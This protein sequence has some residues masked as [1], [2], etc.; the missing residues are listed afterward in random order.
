[1]TGAAELLILCGVDPRA[2][3][4]SVSSSEHQRAPTGASSWQ[5][6]H[7][8]PQAAESRCSTSMQAP[9]SL[10]PCRAGRQDTQDSRNHQLN[11]NPSSTPEVA[12]R[13]EWMSLCTSVF[14]LSRGVTVRS[15]SAQTCTVLPTVPGRSNG[16][17]APNKCRQSALRLESDPLRPHNAGDTG[18]SEAR[19]LTP[20]PLSGLSSPTH[21]PLPGTKGGQPPPS[22]APAAPPHH[23]PS[24]TEA[25]WEI[26]PPGPEECSFLFTCYLGYSIL[27]PAS[28]HPPR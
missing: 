19:A 6:P 8:C 27:S 24:L 14:Y 17:P 18:R 11:S 10:S 1:M 4:W 22:S 9:T 20:S 5:C 13:P 15:K 26:T 7:T 21:R 2:F 3:L 16:S 23:S 12:V 28:Q 25:L